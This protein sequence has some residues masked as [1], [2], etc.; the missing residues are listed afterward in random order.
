MEWTS[1]MGCILS[2]YKIRKVLHI[3]TELVFR[4]ES[5]YG[6]QKR[7]KYSKWEYFQLF[8]KP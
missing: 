5:F 1:A 7:W 8:Y 3:R 2:I 4:I 6:F